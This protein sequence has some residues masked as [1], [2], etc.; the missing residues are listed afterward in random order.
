VWLSGNWGDLI[1]LKVFLSVCLFI[2]SF[3]MPKIIKK[4]KGEI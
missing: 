3:F 1:S 2:F 4:I